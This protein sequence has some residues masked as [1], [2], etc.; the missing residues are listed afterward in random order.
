M[1]Y[2]VGDVLSSGFAS[3]PEEPRRKSK[4]DNPGL[5]N[6]PSIPLAWRDAQKLLQALEGHGMKLNDSWMG[7]VP[8]VE[9]WTG[10]MNS[11][12]ILLKNEQDEIDRAPI[13]NVLGKITGIE[14]PE[15]SIIVGN[16]RDACRTS[17]A[18]YFQFKEPGIPKTSVGSPVTLDKCFYSTY[19]LEE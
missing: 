11:P 18:Y 9:W 4:F 14:Q 7:G 17:P 8:D 10:D 19:I 1:S 15:K 12:M 16:H 5:C 13:Y 6:I 3:L 2:V